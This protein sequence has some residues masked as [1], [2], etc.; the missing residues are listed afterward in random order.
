MKQFGYVVYRMPITTIEYK[1]TD[2]EKNEI[3]LN[4]TINVYGKKSITTAQRYIEKENPYKI[5]RVINT[6]TTYV[7]YYMPVMDFVK[8]AYHE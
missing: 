3:N 1:Y 7:K 8:V 6:T 2:I 4:K 5:V